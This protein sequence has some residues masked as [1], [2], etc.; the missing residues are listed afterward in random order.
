M[1]TKSPIIILAIFCLSFLTIFNSSCKK[2]EE[3]LNPDGV[4]TADKTNVHPLEVVTITPANIDFTATEF[5]ATIGDKS[6]KLVL[7]DNKLVFIMPEVGSGSYSLTAEIEGKSYYLTY[8]V[9]QVEAISDPDAYYADY[10]QR[11][12]SK[13]SEL[14]ASIAVTSDLF[15]MQQVNTDIAAI[16]SYVQQSVGNFQGLSSAEKLSCVNFLEANQDLLSEIELSVDSLQMYANDLY[17]TDSTKGLTDWE[18]KIGMSAVAFTRSVMQV[19]KSIALFVVT[20]PA[21]MPPLTFIGAAA[22][23]VALGNLL[24]DVYNVYQCEMKLLGTTFSVA[25]DQIFEVEKSIPSEY[26]NNQQV[27]LEV[28][29]S[30][31]G[32]YNVDATSSFA[33]VNTFITDLVYFKSIFDV[34]RGWIPFSISASPKTI[35]EISNAPSSN[36]FMHAKYLSITN[37]SNN[38][39][40]CT[41]VNQNGVLMVKFITSEQ[42]DQT[43]NFDITYNH[44]GFA[45][46]TKTVN[47]AVVKVSSDLAFTYQTSWL[48]DWRDGG[49]IT[50]TA[51]GGI[52]PYQYSVDGGTS[53]SS[54]AV[55]SN[56]SKG[57]YNLKI[58]D[59]NDFESETQQTFI[60]ATEFI[61]D[62]LVGYLW[63]WD[64][65]TF[66]GDSIWREETPTRIRTCCYGASNANYYYEISPEMSNNDVYHVTGISG[67]N[68]FTIS[69]NMLNLTQSTWTILEDGQTVERNYL[70]VGK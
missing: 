61:V 34:L 15:N 8:T 19:R 9:T 27:S 66:C 57:Y 21:M 18:L 65:V 67:F 36:L 47:N 16:D 62:E 3:D 59:S 13:K 28:L 23:G 35:D 52:P 12:A 25:R 17:S 26:D 58:K 14:Q 20:I 70:K 46:I 1:K 64:G 31:S 22:V 51:T 24:Y 7:N 56:L 39:V 55:V 6:V 10:I 48:T 40:S 2:E 33:K 5:T 4:I 50:F 68:G 29:G 45:Q 63:T 53:Y 42:T 38:K 44:S 49:R 69:L 54:N 43:F 37:I 30:Y 60:H 41:T 32:F 11:I